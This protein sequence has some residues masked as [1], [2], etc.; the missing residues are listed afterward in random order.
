M[1]EIDFLPKTYV[2]QRAKHSRFYRE[3]G[4]IVAIALVIGG[5]HLSTRNSL[6]HL[7]GYAQAL[8][9]QAMAAQTQKSEVLRLQKEQRELQE[10]VRTQRKLVLPLNVNQVMAVLGTLMPKSMAL[11]TLQITN[12]RPTPALKTDRRSEAVIAKAAEVTPVMKIELVG[13]APTDTDVAD[14]VGRL[15][16]SQM[17][18]NVKMPF[19]HATQAGTLLAREFRIEMEIA[20]DRDY[21]PAPGAPGQEVANA[22]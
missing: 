18:S 2:Q 3:M 16:G 12:P 11:T 1:N 5:W 15:S 17:F 9:A 6:S 7:Q 13:L 22:D 20:L 21:K 10:T 8:E 4:G 14:F 19:S